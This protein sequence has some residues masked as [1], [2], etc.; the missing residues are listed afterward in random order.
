MIIHETPLKDCY[1]IEPKVFGDNRGF[2]LE[3]FNQRVFEDKIGQKINFVQDNHSK[4]ARHVLR[5]M[6]WQIKNPQGKLVRVV[7]GEVY[8]VAVDVRRSSPTFGKWYGLHLSAENKKMLWLPE[9]FAHG[10][11]VTSEFADFLYKTTDYYSPEHER[12]FLWSDSTLN[13]KW[14]NSAAALLSKRDQAL[15]DFKSAEV[16]N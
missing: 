8:D 15:P 4:S 1:I 7:T 13:I 12:G 16:L 10:F 3:S 2:F 9:G 6:H 5:G 11:Q 14:P